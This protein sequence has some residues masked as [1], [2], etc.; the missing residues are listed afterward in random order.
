M[1]HCFD[2]CKKGHTMLSR[3]IFICSR[4]LHV[5]RVFSSIAAECSSATH[6]VQQL[7]SHTERR[8][9]GHYSLRGF[10]ASA[11]PA[12]ATSTSEEVIIDG[13]AVNVGFILVIFID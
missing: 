8:Y 5:E 13:S 9:Q 11:Q 6:P 2:K 10:A 4:R 1:L 12:T 3:C 7:D